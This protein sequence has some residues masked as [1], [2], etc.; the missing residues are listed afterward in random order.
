M[1][2]GYLSRA[3]SAVISD[4]I[5]SFIPE[6][7]IAPE[8]HRTKIASLHS[9]LES[10]LGVQLPL[11]ISLSAPVVLQTDQRTT[12][13]EMFQ[14]S[15]RETRVRP[16]HASIAG[17]GWV[18]NFD[19]SRWFLVLRLGKPAGDELNRLLFASNECVKSFGL[20]TLYDEGGKDCLNSS[21]TASESTSSA[22][23]RDKK[24]HGTSPSSDR[25][26]SFHISI[27]WQLDEPTYRQ[28]EI[29]IGEERLGMAV[30]L[31]I[32]FNCVKLKIGNAV[33]DIPLFV[34]LEDGTGFGRA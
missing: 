27:A 10:D 12:F 28:K 8:L 4:V 23:E 13:Q 31:K 7:S 17:I 26:T 18:P 1:D 30:G 2:G 34:N 32:D 16:F 29:Q 25:T 15:I 3:E 24:G 6:L 19:R 22:K 20:R 21:P 14:D 9:F 5:N 33:V 11:H